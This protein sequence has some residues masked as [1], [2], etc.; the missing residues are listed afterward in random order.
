MKVVQ[1][2]KGKKQTA[3]WSELVRKFFDTIS[4]A[5]LIDIDRQRAI[6]MVNEKYSTMEMTNS[7]KNVVGIIL[8]Q[9]K[10]NRSLLTPKGR[11]RKIE[12]KASQSVSWSHMEGWEIA[13]A[14]AKFFGGDLELTKK[15]FAEAHMFL[16]KISKVDLDFSKIS[17]AS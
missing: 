12:N 17:S 9:T 15:K 13:V 16:Q 1:R 11:I 7:R 3:P 5:A 14:A 10:K 8:R 6:K 2:S 4:D